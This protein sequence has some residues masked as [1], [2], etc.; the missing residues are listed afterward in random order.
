MHLGFCV[1]KP[2]MGLSD[3]KYEELCKTADAVVH[4]AVK[5]SFVDQYKRIENGITDIRT[6]HVKGTLNILEFVCTVKTK[7][8]YQCTM[9]HV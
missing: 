7:V 9:P 5:S 4:L 3:E 2:K 1:S 6:I 8:L